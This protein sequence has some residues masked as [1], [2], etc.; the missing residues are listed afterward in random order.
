MTILPN[1]RIFID[2]Q[3]LKTSVQILYL[4]KS[5]SRVFQE[6]FKSFS[7]NVSTVFQ[8]ISKVFHECFMNISKLV[9]CLQV[10]A[11][12]RAYGGLVFMG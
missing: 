2:Y 1:Y 12:I 11:A 9:V 8:S 6:C 3:A 4:F 10:I 7:K 5:V